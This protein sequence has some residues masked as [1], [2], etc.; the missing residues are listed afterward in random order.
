MFNA[1]G[2]D[3]SRPDGIGV[4]EAVVEGAADQPRRFVPLKRT[5]LRGELSGPL[6]HLRLTQ[7]FGYST[8]ECDRTLEAAY[9]FP[10]PG[11][12]AVIAVRVRFGDI[13][14]RARLGDRRDAEAGYEKARSE[15]RRAALA[16]RESPD[17]FTLQVAG[18]QPDQ[19]VTVETTFVLLARAEGA[20]WSLRIPLTTA[21][22]YVRKDEAGSRS[23]EGQPLAILRDPGHR[24]A[25]DLGLRGSGP[26]ES[27]THQLDVA[28]DGGRRRV[29]LLDGEVV[30]D[31]DCVL[32]W[33]WEGAPDR[34]MLDVARHD[35]PASGFAYFLAMVAPPATR[36][37]GRGLAR[38]VLLLVDHS[39]SMDGPKW[40]AADWAVEKFLA[41][42]TPRDRFALGLFHTTT[43]WFS[44]APRAAEPRAIEE[45][46]A[47]LKANRDQGGTELGVALEQALGQDRGQGEPARHVLIVTDAQSTDVGR[48]LG[49][50]ESESKRPD[51]RRVSVLCIDAAPNSSLALEMAERGG[52]VARFLTS[53]PSE[54]D[55]ASALDEL[56]ADWAEPVHVG[57]RLEVDRPFVRAARRASVEI[58]H[59]GWSGVDLGDLPAGR[60]LWVAGRVPLDEGG[61]LNFRLAT[62]KGRELATFQSEPV[63]ETPEGPALKA[64][65]GARLL[66]EL[67]H[68]IQTTGQA[69]TLR[70]GLVRL[71]YDPTPILNGPAKVY[72]E[73]EVGE[74]RKR[75]RD[76]LVR[77]SLTFGLACS[78]TAFLAERT[79]AGHAVEGSVIV[80]NALPSGWSEDFELSQDRTASGMARAVALKV[81]DLKGHSAPRGRTGGYGGGGGGYG[82]GGAG[83]AA[84]ESVDSFLMEADDTTM[85]QHASIQAPLPVSRRAMAPPSQSADRRQAVVFLGTVATTNGEAVL[86]DTTRVQDAATLPNLATLNR[87]ELRFPDGPPKPSEIR[88]DMALLIFV[89]DLAEPRARVLLSDLIRAGGV[90]PLNLIKTA[91]QVVRIV[92]ID[93]SGLWKQA[94]PRL[95]ITL[96]W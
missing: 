17:V 5:E 42:L 34:A 8:S 63:G 95:E 29:Q 2:F 78:E 31:R 52:G 56:L 40:Q 43:K 66:N 53:D 55:I 96:G 45:A 87:V 58:D 16:T 14:I 54:Q 72:R 11:D 91:R 81:M 88:K 67:E 15:G 60:S 89:D 74:L 1:R 30:P 20:G 7:V 33:Q 21:P 47:F 69:D 68:L 59:P 46:I 86:F 26:V 84:P 35:D 10:L 77:E 50:V 23:A 92:L 73:N 37:P 83:Y 51:R 38:E 76:L 9:R 48:L 62:A 18:L 36:D 12:A 75:A 41:D 65:F 70:D 85:L 82:G 71:G 22:R 24:F 27:S 13:S 25:L 49:L 80:A 64:L 94:S 93:P 61:P 44:K 90:R 57:L 28:R 39:G 4:L 19:E 79:E 6:A 3:N 32:S